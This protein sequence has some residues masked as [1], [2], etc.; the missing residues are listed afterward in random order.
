MD[1]LQIAY[2]LRKKRKDLLPRPEKYA[3][4]EGKPTL[5]FGKRIKVR[6]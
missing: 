6:E 1:D 5:Q 3:K 4:L 2:I